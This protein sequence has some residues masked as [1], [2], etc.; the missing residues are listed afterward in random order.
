[1][2]ADLLQVIKQAATEAVR[3]GEPANIEFGVVK[4]AAPLS[5]QL[6]SK[7]ILSAAFFVMSRNVT[8]YI[9]HIVIDGTDKECTVKNALIPGDRVILLKMQGGQSYA[10]LDRVGG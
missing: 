6:D 3:A 5:I 4:S 9:T 10:V 1:M 7:E 8:D 2:A